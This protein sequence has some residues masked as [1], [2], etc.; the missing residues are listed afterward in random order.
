MNFLWIFNCRTIYVPRQLKNVKLDEIL[1]T[2]DEPLKP[3]AGEKPEAD[4]KPGAYFNCTLCSKVFQ[5]DDAFQRHF[6]GSI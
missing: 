5:T 4:E 2:E 3:E 6:I 1:E